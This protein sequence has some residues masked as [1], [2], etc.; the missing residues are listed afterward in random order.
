M[1]PIAQT[2]NELKMDYPHRRQAVLIAWLGMLLLSRL[3]QII[4]QEFLGIDLGRWWLWLWLAI[5]LVLI[6]VTYECFWRRSGL[7]GGTSVAV[8]VYCR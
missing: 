4:A 6:A 3:P 2:Q 8:G 5:G 7:P 1:A